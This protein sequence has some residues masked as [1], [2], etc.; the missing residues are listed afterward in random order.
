MSN[1]S[2]DL[3]RELLIGNMLRSSKHRA[4][5]KIAFSFEGEDVTYTQLEN[6]S[7]TIAAW[8]QQQ[9]IQKESKIAILFK[10]SKEYIEL[11]WG[12]ALSGCV[13]VPLN[14]RLAKEEL[15]Y[16]INNSD[17]E[18]LFIAEE[19]GD[20]I[21]AIRHQL[22]KVK[23]IVIA[24]DAPM[25]QMLSYESLFKEGLHYKEQPQS[26][27]DAAFI[28]YTSGTTGKPKGAVLTHKNLVMNTQNM[29]REFELNENVR[30]LIVAPLFHIAAMGALMF[31]M[32]A[33]G[34]C[35]IHKDFVPTDVLQSIQEHKLTCLF[36]PP[37]MWNFLT[38][39][40]T[41]DEYDLSS[42]SICISG[43]ET[44]PLE[45]KN[46]IIH[47]FS[48]DGIFET[49]GQTE[50]SPVA[51]V[52]QPKDSMINLASLGKRMVNVDIRIVDEQMNDVQL[53]EVGEI[54][55]RGPTIMK[56]YYNNREETEKA[57]KGGWFHSGDLVSM[58]EEGFIY[59]HDRKKDVIISAGENIYSAEVEDVLYRH[60]AILE[61]AV[62]GV[63]DLSWGESVKAFIVLKTGAVLTEEEIIAFCKERLASYK[64]PKFIE[65]IDALPRNTSGKILKRT[66]REQE[67]SSSNS[68]NNH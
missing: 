55:Y 64:K 49:F 32:L 26:D 28:M 41:I 23:T 14:Y 6:R 37:A 51:V 61:A 62:V 66:L 22:M 15:L 40:P 63:P 48:I 8:L 56:E 43:A 10:N 13:G 12:I 18:I 38:S 7:L 35:I 46:R 42:V 58:D 24:S 52:M 17:S 2:V 33:K 57:F 19:Y 27:D 5:H 59:I 16:I 4:P 36:L 54:V 45:V 31:T 47:Y 1:L 30:Q 29:Y 44:C 65:F 25:E 20:M 9:P 34:T 3:S 11:F 67:T 60:E 53:G 68:L 50:A 21:E 39:V